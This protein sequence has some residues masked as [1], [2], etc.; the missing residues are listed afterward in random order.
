[1]TIFTQNSEMMLFYFWKSLTSRLIE[2]SL[3]L[4][5]ASAFSLQ[6]P[7]L[8]CFGCVYNED[9]LSQREKGESILKTFSDSCVYGDSTKT[10]QIIVS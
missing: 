5:A 7:V 1:M 4:K 8:C 3:T 10:R 9:L 6:P 2:G